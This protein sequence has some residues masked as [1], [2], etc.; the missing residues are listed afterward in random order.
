MFT[1]A[2]VIVNCLQLTPE[3][4]ETEKCIKQ[5]GASSAQTVVL[6]KLLN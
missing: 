3:K 2:F 6:E 1:L 4:I 5:H